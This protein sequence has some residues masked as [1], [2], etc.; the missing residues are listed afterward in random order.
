MAQQRKRR[1]RSAAA[2]RSALGAVIFLIV[3]A[4]SWAGSEFGW[5]GNVTLGPKPTPLPGDGLYVSFI[6]VGQGDSALAVC[7]GETL[8]V[9]AGDFSSTVAVLRSSAAVYSCAVMRP[10]SRIWR[11]T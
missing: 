1:R 10:F 8:L 2:P 4:L 3:A 5:F 9:D 11:R 6:D 7:E